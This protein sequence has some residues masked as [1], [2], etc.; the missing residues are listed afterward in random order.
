MYSDFI[1]TATELF[2]IIA[3]TSLCR[4][5]GEDEEEASMF[6]P[7]INFNEVSESSQST[8]QRS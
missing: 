3:V 6:V 1:R 8:F 7:R 5:S 4:L 2:F